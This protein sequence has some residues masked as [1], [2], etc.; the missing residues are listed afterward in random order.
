MM[1]QYLEAR[2]AAQEFADGLNSGDITYTDVTEHQA[3]AVAWLCRLHQEGRAAFSLG[4][5]PYDQLSYY[6]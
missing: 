6:A 3:S 1:S 4:L 5:I 2:D